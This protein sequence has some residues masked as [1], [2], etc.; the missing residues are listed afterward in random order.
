MFTWPYF[1]LSQIWNLSF[2]VEGHWVA[3]VWNAIWT[4]MFKGG[5]D[6]AATYLCWP[7]NWIAIFLLLCFAIVLTCTIWISAWV[8]HY[9]VWKIII[10]LMFGTL[11]NAG[12]WVI[13]HI[14]KWIVILFMPGFFIGSIIEEIYRTYKNWLG[15]NIYPITLLAIIT[16]VFLIPVSWLG[17][18]AFY[19]ATAVWFNYLY[20]TTP[21]LQN[22]TT[23][24][25]PG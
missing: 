16:T 9:I 6:L 21:S 23:H 7:F 15:R 13:I 11:W 24:L 4:W 5:A 8:L 17:W 25:D 1:D 22:T 14:M 19:I 20:L 12:A 3:W 10:C 18:A 2:L